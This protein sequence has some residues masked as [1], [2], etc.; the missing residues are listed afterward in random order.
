VSERVFG[1]VMDDVGELEGVL[2]GV[3]VALADL[4]A[5]LVPV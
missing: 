5:D 2:G 3:F 1:G 4:V